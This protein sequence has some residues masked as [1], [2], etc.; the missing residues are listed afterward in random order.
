MKNNKANI[1][2]HSGGVSSNGLAGAEP[3]EVSMGAGDDKRFLIAVAGVLLETAHADGDFHFQEA[4]Q[5]IRLM[6]RRYG[7]A[8]KDAV[9]I[10][11]A[12]NSLRYSGRASGD[13]ARTVRS[14]SPDKER[15]GE[16]LSM[17]EQIE[18]SDGV[19]RKS[20]AQAIRQLKKDLGL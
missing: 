3:G 2:E 12:A 20:E 15:R 18:L 10:L 4:Q 16:I 17:A 8:Q 5:A 11:V 19:V 7:L 6:R 9:N 13:F 14:L 1:L